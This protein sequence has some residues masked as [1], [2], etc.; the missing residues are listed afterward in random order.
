MTAAEATRAATAPTGGAASKPG[1]P[2]GAA[3]LVIAEAVNPLDLGPRD[4][5][6]WHR[7]AAPSHEDIKASPHYPVYITPNPMAGSQVG[8]AGRAP[9]EAAAPRP[10]RQRRGSAAVAAQRGARAPACGGLVA[11]RPHTARGVGP[12]GG[13]PVLRPAGPPTDRT[14]PPRRPFPR[15]PRA[16]L[17]DGASD[18]ARQLVINGGG[19]AVETPIFSGRIEIHLKGLA[20]TR[21][22][23]FEGKKRFF[24]IAVQV[25][26][27]FVG[28]C[29]CGGLLCG[30]GGAVGRLSVGHLHAGRLF[31]ERFCPDGSRGRPKPRLQHWTGACPRL[32]VRS[33]STHC[34][35]LSAVFASPAAPPP[36]P[37]TGQV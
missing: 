19:M 32:F 11:G 12:E 28:G 24:Q 29:R 1:K 6:P 26:P 20:T 13:P 4:V 31:V 35:R 8:R 22:G 16:Q 27:C 34:R 3:P 37:Q 33:S 10:G 9:S 14:A 18:P 25:G 2:P 15:R 21:A 5:H 23:V 36:P 30:A 17:F 7:P